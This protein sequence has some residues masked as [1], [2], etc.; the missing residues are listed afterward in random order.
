MVTPPQ[1]LP[2]IVHKPVTLP[3]DEESVGEEERLPEFANGVELFNYA[4]KHRWKLLDLKSALS[5][6]NPAEI[7]DVKDAA[8]ILF[9]DKFKE[10]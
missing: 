7:K 1:V 10:S 6:N 8:A 2:V 3:E 4:L 9:P 5:I